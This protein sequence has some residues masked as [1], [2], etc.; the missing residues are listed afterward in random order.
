MRWDQ[1]NEGKGKAAAGGCCSY[2]W[3]MCKGKGLLIIKIY[4]SGCNV[5][6][7]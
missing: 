7:R 2:W 6:S 3:C 5:H 1:A 4:L